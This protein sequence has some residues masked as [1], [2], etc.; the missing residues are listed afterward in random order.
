MMR[1]STRR[2]LCSYSQIW[3]FCRLC[4][5]LKIRFCERNGRGGRGRG[6]RQQ[7]GRL[8]HRAAAAEV[9]AAPPALPALRCS[10][11]LTMGCVIILLTLGGMAADCSRKRQL[12]QRSAR[13]PGGSGAS[14]GKRQQPEGGGGRR[15]RATSSHWFC[16]TAA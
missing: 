4:K 15:R 5:N 12:Q 10:L 14:G 7:A 6:G 1:P 16:W 3:I 11:R 13:A 2:S 9:H 8:V